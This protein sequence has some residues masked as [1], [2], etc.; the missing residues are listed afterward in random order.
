MPKWAFTGFMG[1]ALALGLVLTAISPAQAQD[2]KETIKKAQAAIVAA[3]EGLATGDK[4]KV[5]AIEAFDLDP[6]MASFKPRARGGIGF[7]EKAG[8]V[9]PNE[10]GIES[11][12]ISLGKK[13]LSA[14][15]AGKFQGAI[16]TLAHQ[17]LAIGEATD[18]KWPESKD[19]AKSKEKWLEFNAIMKDGSKELADAA[20]AKDGAKIKAAAA[21]VNRSCNECH[22]VFRD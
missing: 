6:I 4:S 8:V 11:K 22:T 12:L 2:K 3:G 9:P 16:S 20:K 7:G 15:D 17:V 14:S 1:S 18:A 5:K 10:D 21:K 13:P 19:K